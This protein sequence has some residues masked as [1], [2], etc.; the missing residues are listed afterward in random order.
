MTEQLTGPGLAA[1]VLAWSI[2]I[3][4]SVAMIS[5]AAFFVAMLVAAARDFLND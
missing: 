4:L 5:A 3:T 2:V 1:A